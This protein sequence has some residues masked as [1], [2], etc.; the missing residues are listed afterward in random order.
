MVYIHPD[1]GDRV[2]LALINAS[3]QEVNSLSRLEV[4]MLQENVNPQEQLVKAFSFFITGQPIGQKD[5]EHSLDFTGNNLQQILSM[6]E[7]PHAHVEAITQLFTKLEKSHNYI[8]WLFPT[9]DKS[10]LAYDVNAPYGFSAVNIQSLSADNMALAQQKMCE[11]FMLMLYFY[12]LEYTEGQVKKR[13]D[14][15]VVSFD[16]RQLNWVND[17][18]HNHARISRM[19]DS[20][21]LFGLQNESQALRTCMLNLAHEYQNAFSSALPYWQPTASND[22]S[23]T[24]PSNNTMTDTTQPSHT[25]AGMDY[26]RVPVC[27]IFGVGLAMWA[28]LLCLGSEDFFGDSSRDKLALSILFMAPGMA[29][30]LGTRPAI[31]GKFDQLNGTTSPAPWIRTILGVALVASSYY[32]TC[33]LVDSDNPSLKG[34]LGGVTVVTLVLNALALSI[35]KAPAIYN[36]WIANNS[37]KKTQHLL[38]P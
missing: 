13:K 19:M 30:G 35:D 15:S 11:Y 25:M 34:I 1:E 10:K 16:A 27:L 28:S 2:S 17:G 26:R 9:T 38:N 12:G 14:N 21:T 29:L 31:R 36:E 5:F 23:A 6:L 37:S 8:Q 20:L 24:Q 18:N 3:E 33:A 4:I 22:I 32:F 7:H